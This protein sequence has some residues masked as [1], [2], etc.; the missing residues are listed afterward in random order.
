MVMRPEDFTESARE[1]IS[2]SQ[3]LVRHYRHGQWDVEHVLLALLE[4]Q[5]SVP[6]QTLREMD[7]DP[8]ALRSDVEAALERAPRLQY[9]P[10]QI[11]ATPRVQ[12]VLEDAKT[13]AERLKDEFIGTEHI[14]IAIS[15]ERTGDSAEA[16]RAR[17]ID[18]ER[19]YQALTKVRGDKR[20]TDPNADSRYRSLEKFSRDLTQLARQGRL[21]PVVA[22]DGVVQ[23]AIQT[24]SRR[25]KNN[26]V[27]LGE[28]GVGKTAVVEGLAQ[29]IVAGGV[30]DAIRGKRV[31]WLDMPGL[32]AGSKFRGEFE[33]RLKAVMDEVMAAKG[34]IILFI[35]EIHTVV[36]AGGAE[37]AIDASNMMKPALARGELQVIGATT[38]DEY[39]RYIEKDSALER[40]FHPVW[41][42][43]PS[44]ED[45]VLMVTALRP[46][47]EAHHGV[48]IDDS[49]VNASVRLSKRYVT[50]RRLPDKAVDL[51]DEAAAKLRLQMSSMPDEIK[52]LQRRAAE[53]EDQE[54]AAANRADYQRASELRAERIQ[55]E[56]QAATQRDA[57]LANE[58]LDMVVSEDDIAALIAVW[59]GV[60]VSRLLQS[61]AERL[62]HMEDALHARVIGQD[63]AVSVVS[64]AIRR[65]RA[66][67]KDPKRPIGAFMF[68]GPTGVGKTELARALAQFLFDDEEALIRIDMSEY[69]EHHTISRLVG[70]PPGYVGYDEGGQLTELVRRRPFR[71]VLFDEIEKAHPQVFNLLLQ[72]LEDGRLTDGH[73]NAVDFRNTVIIMTSNLGTGDFGRNTTLG[74]RREDAGFAA[75]RDRIRS[76][77][78]DALK[79]TFR[80][81]F[82]NRLDETVTFDPLTRDDLHRIVDLMANAVQ[83]RMAEQ[84]IT[85]VVSEEAKD[86]L[87]KEGYD[88]VF[89]ARPLRRAVQRHV[90]NPLANR[91]LST[92]FSHGDTVHVDVD[93]DRRALTFAVSAAPAAPAEAV[94]GVTD[95]TAID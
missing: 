94:A 85:L 44:E 77:V 8:A 42:E 30:P 22:R 34:E 90:E 29:A 35:D 59:T 14:F 46:R 20:V 1:A 71:V 48:T 62:L 2:R 70:A 95:P 87:V 50:D 55:V 74:F 80:P 65:A 84:E 52:E 17:Q 58:K 63:E 78:E 51:I 6:S 7:V 82:L 89:G 91:I 83:E 43:E 56:H 11:Y 10:T 5:E 19:V 32:V 41:V 12:R 67:L 69:M 57:W 93:A 79:R 23:Q 61:E 73:G 13:E 39:R 26:P 9:E 27:L 45:A 53:L 3:D 66:G 92:E 76:T 18:K 4:Q 31:L 37:G 21:D 33:E 36:G 47:Y 60:P 15:E 40:R 25:T 24:L 86:W 75:Q 88:P 81:E 16:L 68:L 64:E 54:E 49:A 28:A 38:P 72:L